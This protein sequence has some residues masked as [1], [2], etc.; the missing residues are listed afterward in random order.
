MSIEHAWLDFLGQNKFGGIDTMG[1]VK[2]EG[3][4]LGA[5]CTMEHFNAD[6][7]ISFN[8]IKK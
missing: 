3:K 6:I 7:I 8:K 4:L 5:F 2:E 1:A